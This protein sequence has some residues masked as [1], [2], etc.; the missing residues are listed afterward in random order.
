MKDNSIRK[1]LLLVLVVFLGSCLHSKSILAET[2]NVNKTG[3]RFPNIAL[4]EHFCSEDKKYLGLSGK[5]SYL[6]SNLQADFIVVEF[7][8]IYCSV[9]QTHANTFNRLYRLIEEDLLVRE[10]TKMIGIALG[11]NTTEVEY[12]KKYFD[13][14][15]PC[16]G[17]PDFTIYKSMREPRTPLL[18]LVDKRSYPFKILSVLDFTK[19]P[20]VLMK[21]IRDEIINKQNR[22]ARPKAASLK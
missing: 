11:N 10:K 19:A 7:F 20:E 4:T 22:I 16:I 17:D 8:S 1:V 9:C 3:E 12:F 21:E 15:Y 2:N 14:T 13:I 6:L 5:K 18:L